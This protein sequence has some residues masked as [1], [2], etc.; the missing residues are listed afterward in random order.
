MLCVQ[1]CTHNFIFFFYLFLVFKSRLEWDS[2]SI[3][4]SRCDTAA[5]PTV[6]FRSCLF[7]F[8]LDWSAR[9]LMMPAGVHFATF[10]SHKQTN[11]EKMSSRSCRW[12]KAILKR[13]LTHFVGH[14]S[15]DMMLTRARAH[16]SISSLLSSLEKL[17]NGKKAP[18]NCTRPSSD[19]A[20]SLT[21]RLEFDA[22]NMCFDV[23]FRYIFHNISP[24]RPGAERPQ[25]GREIWN[26]RVQCSAEVH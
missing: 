18:A 21:S 6:C 8:T 5:A 19:G 23:T 16:K 15:S 20:V 10:S 11:R 9:S 12:K 3:I 13:R 2:I 25:T 4:I 24:H 1:T 17:L 7:G 26:L 22:Y 14:L